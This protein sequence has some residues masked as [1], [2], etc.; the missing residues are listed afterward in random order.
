MKRL[1]IIELWKAIGWDSIASYHK[2]LSSSADMIVLDL[3]DPNVVDPVEFWCAAEDHFGTDSI[4][5]RSSSFDIL[6]IKESNKVNHDIAMCAGMLLQLDICAQHVY[7]LFGS[8]DIA[9]I[10]AGHGSFRLA[11]S[12]IQNRFLDK[13]SYAGFDIIKR[14]ESQIMVGDIDGNFSQDQVF[15]YTDQFNLFYSANTFQHLSKHQI[16]KYLNQVYKMLPHGGYF[17]MMYVKD[18][19]RTYHYGQAVEIFSIDELKTFVK[20]VGFEIFGS[21]TMNIK[22]SITP[23]CF[24]LKKE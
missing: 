20:Q 12:N 13:T 10:G 3:L 8:V 18:I 22:N 21:S 4:C 2:H 1:E 19:E 6:S 9:E 7:K 15:L 11:Y 14:E 5:N 17:C 24:V 16:K 23:Y